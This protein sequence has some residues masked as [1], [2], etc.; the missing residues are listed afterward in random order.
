MH[1]GWF[2]LQGFLVKPR[3]IG[4]HSSA[5]RREP[6]PLT[7]SSQ[8]VSIPFCIPIIPISI[9]TVLFC[10]SNSFWF[11]T[12][13]FF[14]KKHPIVWWVSVRLIVIRS[15]KIFEKFFIQ[16]SKFR[17][18]LYNTVYNLPSGHATSFRLRHYNVRTFYRRRNDVKTIHCVSKIYTFAETFYLHNYGL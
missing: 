16:I 14:N 3:Q 9:S 11:R 13:G 6:N 12:S 10:I 7:K 18:K 1:C 5:K 4:F 8:L 17:N 2:Y 15:K